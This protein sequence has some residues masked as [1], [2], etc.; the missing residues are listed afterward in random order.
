MVSFK[1]LIYDKLSRNI[2]EKISSKHQLWESGGVLWG[3]GGVNT[4]VEIKV[5]TDAIDVVDN[6]VRKI[7]GI[8]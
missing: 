4:E 1:F 2:F 6:E 3:S 8:L 5:N 7:V